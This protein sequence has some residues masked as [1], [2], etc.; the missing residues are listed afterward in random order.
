MTKSC[1]DSTPKHYHNLFSGQP[2]HP[3]LTSPLPQRPP[4]F[5][6]PT[7]LLPT[8]KNPIYLTP[9]PDSNS[10]PLP[11]LPPHAC[12]VPRWQPQ[13]HGDP[14]VHPTFP[15][16]P[17]KTTV[18]ATLPLAHHPDSPH[19][20]PANPPA[21]TTPFPPAIAYSVGFHPESDPFTPQN[22]SHDSIPNKEPLRGRRHH[23]TGPPHR[24]GPA[25]RDAAVFGLQQ[26]DAGAKTRAE[27]RQRAPHAGS[28][29]QA[30]LRGVHGGF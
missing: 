4:L 7:P 20:P 26:R 10:P 17:E 27:P 28:R 29:A 2:L 1:T 21:A 6:M 24:A 12:G 13:I 15:Q 8:S 30:V 22:P 3:T 14:I 9:T 25:G 5:T 16:E 19:T 11:P 18:F 23:R